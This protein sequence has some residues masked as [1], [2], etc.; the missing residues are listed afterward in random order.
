MRALT[1]ERREL[2]RRYRPLAISIGRGLSRFLRSDPKDCIGAAYLALC[3]S[4]VRWEDTGRPFAAYARLRI[5]G[6]VINDARARRR[7]RG[8]Y[9][10]HDHEERLLAPELPEDVPDAQV[11]DAFRSLPD[12]DQEILYQRLWLD[13]PNAEIGREVGLSEKG[14]RLAVSAALMRIRVLV[15]LT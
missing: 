5:R 7:Q 8:R 2:A 6:A 9:L 13:R 1:S 14:V 3:E 12:R 11:W 10:D 15:D 4:A